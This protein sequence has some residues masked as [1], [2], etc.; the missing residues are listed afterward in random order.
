[1]RKEGV[2]SRPTPDTAI[3]LEIFASSPHWYAQD[4]SVMLSAET[5]AHLKVMPLPSSDGVQGVYLGPEE[6]RYVAA[7]QEAEI[8]KTLKDCQGSYDRFRWRTLAETPICTACGSGPPSGGRGAGL[9][10]GEQGGGH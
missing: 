5:M 4:R 7:I 8:M 1:M 2:S 6:Q 10:A 3:K 9:R